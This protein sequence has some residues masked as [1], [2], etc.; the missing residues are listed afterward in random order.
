MENYNPKTL[1]NDVLWSKVGLGIGA[2]A[3]GS[4]FASTVFFKMFPEKIVKH[5][6]PINLHSQEITSAAMT[7]LDSIVPQKIMVFLEE[8]LSL[9]KPPEQVQGPQLTPQ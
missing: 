1:S 8:T 6:E 2:F 4:M 7:R 5:G 3:C 9:K